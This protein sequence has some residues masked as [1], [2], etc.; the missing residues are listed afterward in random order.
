[1]DAPHGKPSGLLAP[2]RL[3]PGGGSYSVP[4]FCTGRGGAAGMCRKCLRV[5]LPE[6][7]SN[8]TIRLEAQL[9]LATARGR[10]ATVVFPQA[11]RKPPSSD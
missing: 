8:A 3:Q 1:M 11:S 10:T 9:E 2:A 5:K 7:T 6:T 4:Q